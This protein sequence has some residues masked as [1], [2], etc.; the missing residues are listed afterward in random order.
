MWML[1]NIN[2]QITNLCYSILKLYSYLELVPS[3]NY[4]EHTSA[5]SKSTMIHQY[6]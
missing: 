1:I 2:N 4:S 6:P 3:Q 5:C